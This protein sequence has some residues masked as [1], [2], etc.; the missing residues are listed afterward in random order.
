VAWWGADSRCGD[1][2][3][4]EVYILEPDNLS[5]DVS[6]GK[7]STRN[8]GS[9]GVFGRWRYSPKSNVFIAINSVDRNVWLYQPD[10]L[11]LFEE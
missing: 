6:V 10:P 8:N 11:V 1:T 4:N 9:K 2:Q 3:A 7:G 5:V